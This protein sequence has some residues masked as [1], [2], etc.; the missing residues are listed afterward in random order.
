[1]HVPLPA[2]LLTVLYATAVAVAVAGGHAPAG[3]VVL[4]GLVARWVVRSRRS[5]QPARRPA[6]AVPE[7]ARALTA[8]P[9]RAA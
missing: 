8:D 3:A 4:A 6:V 9:A 5:G 1:M 2:V 7:P